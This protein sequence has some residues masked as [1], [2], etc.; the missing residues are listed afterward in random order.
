MPTYEDNDDYS[1]PNRRKS[2]EV[3][4]TQETIDYMTLLFQQAVAE[5]IKSAVTED[6]AARVIAAG[7]TALQRQATEHAGRVVMG[8]IVGLA[9]IQRVF[10]QLQ[11]FG[12]WDT[13]YHGAQPSIAQ[14]QGIGP[15]QCWLVVPELIR[16]CCSL[17]REASQTAYCDGS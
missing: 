2:A 14:R 1:G 8:G 13:I 11:A 3:R 10:V 4:L 7:L 9:R 16:L 6:M 15:D 5:G 12:G 17:Q